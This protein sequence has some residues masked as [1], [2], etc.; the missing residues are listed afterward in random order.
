MKI[1]GRRNSS[2]V[3]KV[4]WAASELGLAFD[5]VEVGGSFGGNREPSYLALNPNGLV[6]AIQDGDLVLWESNAIVRYLSAKFGAGML[7]PSAPEIKARADQW[8]DWQL[9]T[10][11]PPMVTAYW[12]L[13]RL[14]PE[15]RDNAAI[16][17][18]KT[19]L[20]GAM[21]ILDGQ[22]GKTK[23]VAGDIFSMGDIPAAIMAH[24]YRHLFPDRPELPNLER[25]YASISGRP[26]FRRS[27]AAVPMT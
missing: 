16:A 6:P 22:L 19:Q 10:L 4:L 13:I 1:W 12:G 11:G 25:W 18:A 9:S 23:F 26:P 20:D 17:A 7:E 14:P 2:N 21:K 15:K 3:Q 5:H 24:R 27:V 8:M